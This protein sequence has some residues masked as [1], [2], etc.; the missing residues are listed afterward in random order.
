MLSHEELREFLEERHERYNQPNFVDSDPIQIPH[1]FLAKQDIEISAFL[2][3][4]IA[5]GN[6][7]MIIR[8]AKKLVQLMGNKPYEFITE[9]SERDFERLPHFVHRTFNNTDLTFF[10]KSLKHIYSTHG[11]LEQ[12]FT[13]GYQPQE[14]VHSALTHF[15]AVFFE[16]EHEQRSQKHLSNVLKGASAKRLNMF[17]MWMVRNDQRGVHFGLWNHI[18]ASK[19]MLP[20]DVHTGR[21]GRCVGLLNRK[22]ND[23]KAVEEITA[24]L[25]KFSPEDP[26]K[27]DFSLFGAGVFEKLCKEE[28]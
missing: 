6:R 13:K 10:L 27:Y 26:I 28:R 16:V 1:S 21:V 20:L 23:W 15:R 17:L 19:L 2:T 12:V 3:A 7:T 11:G 5:W 9:A 24:S 25:R 4:T 8:N 18:S 14:A 22:S